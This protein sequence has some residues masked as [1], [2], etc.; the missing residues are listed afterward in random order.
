MDPGGINQ[1]RPYTLT[2]WIASDVDTTVLECNAARALRNHGVSIKAINSFEVYKEEDIKRPSLVIQSCVWPPPDTWPHLE[3]LVHRYTGAKPSKEDQVRFYETMIFE[4]LVGQF[5]SGTVVTI[6]RSHDYI[7]V[8]STP[9][10]LAPLGHVPGYQPMHGVGH[11]PHTL[12]GGHDVLIARA[13]IGGPLNP[14]DFIGTRGFFDIV[15]M[16]SAATSN[17]LQVIFLGE[18]D[19]SLSLGCVT[20]MLYHQHVAKPLAQGWTEPID[21]QLKVLGGYVACYAEYHTYAKEARVRT[22]LSEYLARGNNPAGWTTPTEDHLQPLVNLITGIMWLDARVVAQGG[23][24]SFY[25][26]SEVSTMLNTS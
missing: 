4:A 19:G 26:Q 6:N 20:G 1:A 17:N 22:L 12:G 21:P 25:I 15:G 5:P 10:V 7:K 2:G 9:A 23:N 14:Q 11:Q 13:Q 24:A 3:H 8:G 16:C 18:F